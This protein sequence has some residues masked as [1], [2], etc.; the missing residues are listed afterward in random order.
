MDYKFKTEPYE[1]QLQALGASHNKENFAFHIVYQVLDKTLSS[2]EVNKTHKEIIDALESKLDVA[3]KERAAIESKLDSAADKLDQ[4]E[5]ERRALE[6]KLD[7]AEQ[8]RSAL[9]VK[10]GRLLRDDDDDDDDDD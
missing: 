10:L 3:A 6:A 2:K 9:E 1:H 4:A 5:E 8:E 7:R